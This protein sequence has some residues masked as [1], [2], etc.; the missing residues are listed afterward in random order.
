MIQTEIEDSMNMKVMCYIRSLGKQKINNM[1]NKQR[2]V[3][4]DRSES[5]KVVKEFCGELYMSE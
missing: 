5:V 1:Q 2:I 4:T 3:V